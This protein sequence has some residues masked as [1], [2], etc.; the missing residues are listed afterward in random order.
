MIVSDEKIRET[1]RR[2]IGTNEFASVAVQRE[3]YAMRE[4]YEQVIYLMRQEI[5]KLDA[6]IQEYTT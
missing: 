1:A 2:Y 6:I 5:K 3:L 4:E